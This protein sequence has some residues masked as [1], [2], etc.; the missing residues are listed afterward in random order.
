[1]YNWPSGTARVLLSTLSDVEKVRF[2]KNN[3]PYLYPNNLTYTDEFLS[4]HPSYGL[5][6]FK[7]GVPVKNT[8]YFKDTNNK[9]SYHWIYNVAKP[10][11]LNFSD[12][13]VDEEEDW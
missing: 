7:N 1:M 2:H 13:D 4:G 10:K 6:G 8:Y 9:K 3:T 12:L 11:E 5:L